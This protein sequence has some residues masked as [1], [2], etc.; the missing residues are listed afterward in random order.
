MFDMLCY[1]FDI[2]LVYVIYVALC[3]YVQTISIMH[4]FSHTLYSMP[5]YVI[6]LY[7][8]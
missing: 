4:R 5:A 8:N 6:C 7:Y 2:T 3:V 1:H